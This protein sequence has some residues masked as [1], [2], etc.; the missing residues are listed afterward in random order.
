MST[1]P[2]AK[3]HGRPAREESALDHQC[4]IRFVALLLLILNVATGILAAPPATRPIGE[5][6]AN[7]P[8]TAIVTKKP[9]VDDQLIPQSTAPANDPRTTAVRGPTD[10]GFSVQRVV[11]SLAVVLGLIF[12][13][14]WV[15]RRFF[16]MPGGGGGSQAVQ[17]LSRTTLSPRQHLLL[18]HVGRRVVLV[19]NSGRR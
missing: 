7:T 12:A 17:V 1:L 11:L 13:L 4:K 15:G 5:P 16:A 2:T 3:W 14:R 6:L 8:D 18:I 9:S 10:T 19:A